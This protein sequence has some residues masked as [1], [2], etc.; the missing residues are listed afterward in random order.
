MRTLLH[1]TIDPME[2]F[3]GIYRTPISKEVNDNNR[4]FYKGK[5]YIGMTLRKFKTRFRY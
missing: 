4:K 1:N 5:E 3:S 2:E